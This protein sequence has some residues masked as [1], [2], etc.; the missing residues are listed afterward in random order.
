[1]DEYMV[2]R[3]GEHHMLEDCSL[4]A[5]LASGE[6]DNY[7]EGTRRWGRGWREVYKARVMY[8]TMHLVSRGKSQ[9]NPED[10]EWILSEGATMD[11]HHLTMHLNFIDEFGTE[12]ETRKS[13]DLEGSSFITLIRDLPDG[14]WEEFLVRELV[15]CAITGRSDHDLLHLVY[16]PKKVRGLSEYL[17]IILPWDETDTHIVMPRAQPPVTS[18]SPNPNNVVVID[19]NN[20]ELSDEEVEAMEQR[21][22]GIIL[23]DEEEEEAEEE[24]PEYA[25][26]SRVLNTLPMERL[27]ARPCLGDDGGL[28]PQ[29]LELWGRN[30][31]SQRITTYQVG[32]TP[33]TRL[34]FR[35][36]SSRRRAE[37]NDSSEEE[38][39]HSYAGLS[40]GPR[41]GDDQ[42]D[43]NSDH[44]EEGQQ[45][46][47][48][49]QSSDSEELLMREITWHADS[50]SVSALEEPPVEEEE[51]EQQLDHGY[52][53]SDDIISN[54]REEEQQSDSEELSTHEITLQVDSDSVSVLDESLEVEEEEQQ[55]EH[56]YYEL[57]D[58]ETGGQLEDKERLQQEQLEDKQ[59]LEQE[60]KLG[61][62]RLKVTEALERDAT[63]AVGGPLRWHRGR[64]RKAAL[65]LKSCEGRG[66]GLRIRSL[67]VK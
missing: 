18:H 67:T 8:L 59:Q 7:E 52:E 65:L 21:A 1:M 39:E 61:R 25:R 50:D 36:R 42:N 4:L 6:I 53:K 31:V 34:P 40:L 5:R 58:D 20:T 49:L 56:G 14:E 19:S 17:G 29:L 16:G 47:Q 23:D 15:I 45:L 28:A 10:H 27:I 57:S 22:S 46:L 64:R 13:P 9:L 44:M 26:S 66:F 41:I 54:R 11:R 30:T 51:E 38:V 3:C 63:R 60:R 24:D 55:L 32:E 43:M 48:G 12:W 2:L 62:R 33:S 35:M 37:L